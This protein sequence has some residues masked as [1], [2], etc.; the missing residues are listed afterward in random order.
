M[1]FDVAEQPDDINLLP[2]EF[3]EAKQLLEKSEKNQAK[4]VALLQPF[5]KARLVFGNIDN[6]DDLFGSL[7]EVESDN[8]RLV[9]VDFSSS[10]FPRCKAEADFKVDLVKNPETV[11]FLE[12]ES[13]N[14]LLSDAVVFYWDVERNDATE[15]LDFTYGDHLGVECFPFFK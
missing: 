3:N 9:A 1:K 12:W 7:E 10:P 14:S 11:D 6:A 4:A 2:S 13:E 8:V 15:D 5:V